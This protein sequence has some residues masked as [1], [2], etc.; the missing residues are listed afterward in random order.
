MSTL[1]QTATPIMNGPQYSAI[2]KVSI[3]D[4]QPV[5]AEGVRTLLAGSPD[6][7]F[8]ETSDS[9][10]QAMDLVRRTSPNVLMLDKAFG[11]Q[12]ILEW[13]T[14]LKA[15]DYGSADHDLVNH[16]LINNGSVNR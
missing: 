3:C 13:L 7:V 8:A 10:A 1:T 15:N 14:E 9:L 4:T 6:L 16:D 5:T 2:K 12:A 11:I